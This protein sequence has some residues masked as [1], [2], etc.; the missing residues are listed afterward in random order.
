MLTNVPW[1]AWNLVLAGVPLALSLVLF[2]PARRPSPGWWF[3]VLT[4]LLF[5]P[6]APYVL[7]DVVHLADDVRATENDVVVSV[8]VI[9]SYVVFFLIGF[10]CYAVSVLR[11]ERWLRFRDWSRGR[12]LAVELGLHLL[13]TVGVFLGRF[14][15]FNSWDLVGRPGAVAD[16]F[17]T[18][19]AESLIVLVAT[20]AVL[21]GGTAALRGI[22][23]LAARLV[24][25]P[26]G[27]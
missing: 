22:G 3:G 14:F 26:D 18:P 24:A 13:C 10:G 1:M 7:T 6:N 17:G 15:R 21:A 11:V 23:V 8:G 9:P 20:F 2:A 4:F 27:R 19:T 25:E 12:V 5:L 16:V